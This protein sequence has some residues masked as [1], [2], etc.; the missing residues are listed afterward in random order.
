[1]GRMVLPH[2]QARATEQEGG[3]LTHGGCTL[4]PHSAVIMDHPGPPLKRR[5]PGPPSAPHAPLP[6]GAGLGRLGETRGRPEIA[7]LIR[8]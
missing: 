4:L 8:E 2:P 1:M 3:A 5:P 6:Q 7:P